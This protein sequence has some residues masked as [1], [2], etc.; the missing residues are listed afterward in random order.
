MSISCLHQHACVCSIYGASSGMLCSSG[1]ACRQCDPLPCLLQGIALLY[2]PRPYNLRSGR[3][4]RAVDVPLV[5]E[6]FHEHSPQ[7]YPVKVRV[8]YQKLLK[9][10]VLNVLHHR[11]PKNLKK[12]SLFKVRLVARRFV[13]VA[14]SQLGTC[15]VDEGICPHRKHGM[16]VSF[17]H[18]VG[19]PDMARC[20][21]DMAY[22]LL[23]KVSLLHRRR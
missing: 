4:R 6:W 18:C 14:R 12:K 11:S 10:Y 22:C 9:M 5:N 23:L 2:A 17:H 3:T 13:F 21:H 15:S 8:S 16:Q 20:S 1:R 7:S 19:L